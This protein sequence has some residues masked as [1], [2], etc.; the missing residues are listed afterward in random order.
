MRNGLISKEAEDIDR[1]KMD[2]LKSLRP[3]GVGAVKE[4][5]SI[6]CKIY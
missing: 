4:S 5:Q 2:C 6:D 3:N 1:E